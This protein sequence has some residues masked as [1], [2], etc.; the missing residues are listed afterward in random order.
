MDIFFSLQ[1]CYPSCT[2]L[3]IFDILNM[4]KQMKRGAAMPRSC[5]HCLR[6][7]PDD[8]RFC[9][10]CGL[11][12]EDS[13]ITVAPEGSLQ[14]ADSPSP[15]GAVVLDVP[16]GAVVLIGDEEPPSLVIDA[17]PGASVTISDVPPP[18]IT[19]KEPSS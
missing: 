2:C 3:F 4:K 7:Y 12:T 19:G 8:F 10:L 16:A 11:K 6:S 13:V 15:P 5:R 17:P 14:P 18:G 9:P 1:K